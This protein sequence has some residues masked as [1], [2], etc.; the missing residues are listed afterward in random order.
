M[1]PAATQ[2]IAVR[3][4]EANIPQNTSTPVNKK[5]MRSHFI[6]D[7]IPNKTKATVVAAALIP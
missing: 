3:V 4:P 7:V 6:F 5:N 2:K 1:K